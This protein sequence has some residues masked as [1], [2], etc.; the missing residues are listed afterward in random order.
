MSSKEDS[1]SGSTKIREQ[2]N[3]SLQCPKLTESNY[4]TWALL[5]ETILKAYG[6]WEAVSSEKEVDEK[7]ANTTKAMVL[8]TLP[9]DI[10]MQVA[11][12]PTTKKVWDTIKVRHLG[13]DLVQKARLQTLRSKLEKLKMEENE[14][15]SD[16]SGKLGS[17]RAKF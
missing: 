11:Q 1:S 8:Q 2:G 15:V 6:L 12:H 16:F 3:I 13:A 4:T 14:T 9:E 17:I 7:K 5:M 10:L